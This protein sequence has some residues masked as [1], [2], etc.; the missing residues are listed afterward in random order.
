MRKIAVYVILLMISVVVFAGCNNGTIRN[1]ETTSQKTDADNETTPEET[2]S[3]EIS[4]EDTTTEKPTTEEPEQPTTEEVVSEEETTGENGAT[5]EY[6]CNES[7]IPDE[8]KNIITN[9]TEYEISSYLYGDIDKDNEKELM[10]SYIDESNG[11]CKILILDNETSEPEEFYSIE[12]YAYKDRCDLGLINLG[13]KLHYVVNLYFSMSTET[14]A[15]ILEE[16]EEGVKTVSSFG[17]TVWQSENG[18]IIIQNAY[19]GSYLD[20]ITGGMVGRVWTYSYLTYDAESGQ[21]KEYVANEISEEEFLTFENAAENLQGI[22][23]SYGEV[24]V[25]ITLFK[26]NNGIM[27]V[28]CEYETDTKIIYEYYTLHYEDNEIVMVEELQEGS[29]IK[30]F[31][32]L[33]EA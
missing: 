32:G 4:S 17:N 16:S 13:D 1:N 21:Y 33:E 29:I 20:K 12:L 18:N 3:E 2:E 6:T 8:M 23:N 5:I 30:N 19:Y 10:A 28:Q 11:Q 22:R 14:S 24:D 15:Y 26:R 9:Y 27:Y 25:K 7:N 31:T